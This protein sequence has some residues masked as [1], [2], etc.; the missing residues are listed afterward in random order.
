MHAIK[1]ILQH[2]SHTITFIGNTENC[3][4]KT[5]AHKIIKK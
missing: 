3:D 5:G 2:N 1:V 4:T